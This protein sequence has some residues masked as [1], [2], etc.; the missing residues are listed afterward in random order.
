MWT[1]REYSDHGIEDWGLYD[2]QDL[3]EDSML[4]LERLCPG[5]YLELVEVD[6]V[7]YD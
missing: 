1:V 3:A 4:E 6:D 5:I 2:D 7:F